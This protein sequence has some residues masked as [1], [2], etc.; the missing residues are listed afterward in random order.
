[1]YKV[2]K[3]NQKMKSIKKKVVEKTKTCC[4]L[5]QTSLEIFQMYNYIPYKLVKTIE[6]YVQ[7]LSHLN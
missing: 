1:M 7:D 3:L 2:I 4:L 5:L 6:I